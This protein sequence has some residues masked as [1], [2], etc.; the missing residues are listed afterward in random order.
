MD[1]KEFFTPLVL[2]G[3]AI[4]FIV[5]SALVWLSKGNPG[6]VRRKL[7]LGGMLL[8]LTGAVNGCGGLTGMCYDV[9][10]SNE[11]SVSDV[12]QDGAVHLDLPSNNNVAGTIYQRQGDKFSFRLLDQKEQ[13]VQRA[14]IEALDGKYDENTEEFKLAIKKDLGTGSYSLTFYSAGANDQTSVEPHYNTY[15]VQVTN[16]AK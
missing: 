16:A 2:A 11:F 9:A 12:E 15:K 4:A 6:L 5:V 14:D 8:A 7:R 13:E 1:K 10:M 3:L